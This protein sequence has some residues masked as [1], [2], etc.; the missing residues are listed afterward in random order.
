MSQ[1]NHSILLHEPGI[2][3]SQRF[4]A[5]QI[6]HAI[7]NDWPDDFSP[8]VIPDLKLVAVFSDEKHWGLHLENAAGERV[9]NAMTPSDVCPGAMIYYGTKDGIRN[10]CRTAMLLANTPHV[11]FMIVR[12]CPCFEI[13]PNL[14]KRKGTLRLRVADTHDYAGLRNNI[15]MCSRELTGQSPVFILPCREDRAL[16]SDSD[17]VVKKALVLEEVDGGILTWGRLLGHI[18]TGQMNGVGQHV[19]FGPLVSV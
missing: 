3:T 13:N 6:R 11:S 10:A 2:S 16:L 19:F 12:L 15:S 9:I 5:V 18:E 4:G 17:E 1:Q 8:E 14:A 7:D